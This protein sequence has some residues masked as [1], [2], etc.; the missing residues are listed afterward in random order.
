[1]GLDIKTKN[2]YAIFNWT[3]ASAFIQWSD[4]HLKMSPFPSWDGGNGQMVEFGK[5]EIKWSNQWIKRFHK[6]TQKIDDAILDM[7]ISEI[8]GQIAY[9]CYEKGMKDLAEKNKIP[10]K[11]NWTSTFP[12][13]KVEWE[14][15]Q[16]IKWYFLL[17]D[18]LVC[19]YII[20]G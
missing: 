3:G 16:A 19:G 17:K 4:K 10:L 1:M 14:Y 7:G 8:I 20:Y 6:Y 15:I 12:K 18:A 2:D 5:K 11:E 13:E 9:R